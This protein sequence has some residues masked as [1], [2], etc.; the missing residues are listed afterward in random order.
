MDRTTRRWAVAAIVASALAA[1][2]PSGL[3]AQDDVNPYQAAPDVRAGRQLFERHCARCHGV[4]ARGGETG[5]DLTRGQYRH[6]STD[7]GLFQVVSRGVDGTEMPG[8]RRARNDQEVWQVVAYL[9]SLGGGPRV[10]VPGDPSKGAQ[11]YREEGE[12]VSC[13]MI[14]GVGGTGGPDLSAVGSRR[15]PGDLRSDLVDP[16]ARV[17]PQWWRM[18]VTHRDGTRVEGRRMNE[19]TYSVRILDEDANLWSFMKRDL[20]RS[21]RMETSS[22][23][24]YAERLSADELQDLVAYLYELTGD[25]G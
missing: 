20:I 21:E 1:P 22:M 16:D 10:E 15:S 23:P 3:T 4:G 18:R 9:R 5:P 7:V 2:W 25:E 24:S 12:C 6:A 13:H 8:F 14:D 19:G 17:Q 11:I